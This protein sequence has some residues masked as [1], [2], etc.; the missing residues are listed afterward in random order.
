MSKPVTIEGALINCI[1][2]QTAAKDAWTGLVIDVTSREAMPDVAALTSEFQAVEEKI[3]KMFS[4]TA[5]PV[6]FRNNKA[7]FFKAV[8]AG[9]PLV[10][11]HHVPRNKADVEKDLA[12]KTGSDITT[13]VAAEEQESKSVP[14]EARSPAVQKFVDEIASTLEKAV[15]DLEEK[16]FWRFV[17]DTEMA[18]NEIKKIKNA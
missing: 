11:E 1:V 13:G 16:D 4:I 15:N 14:L 5:L 9:V 2:A 7:T 12:A 8:K 10:D 6:T 3:K 17:Q 18:L